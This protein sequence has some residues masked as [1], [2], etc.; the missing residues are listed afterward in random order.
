MESDDEAK[1]GIFYSFAK[2]KTI[3]NESDVDDIFEL[4]C[5]TI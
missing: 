4:V 3:I 1:Y 5:S 2:A